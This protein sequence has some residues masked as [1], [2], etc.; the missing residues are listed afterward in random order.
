LSQSCPP[1]IRSIDQHHN[2]ADIGVAVIDSF[3]HYI[4]QYLEQQEPDSQA[5]LQEF[6]G[7]AVLNA[8]MHITKLT[9][10]QTV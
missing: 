7:L 3:T 8:L 2:D 5:N 6:V 1:K 10:N 9:A 4:L